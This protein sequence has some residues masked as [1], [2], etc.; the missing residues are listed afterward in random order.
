MRKLTVFFS[1]IFSLSLGFAHAEDNPMPLWYSVV[2][3]GLNP[4]FGFVPNADNLTAFPIV[5]VP[6][7]GSGAGMSGAFSAV[8]TDISFLDYNPAGSSRLEMSEFAFFYNSMINGANLLGTAFATRFGDM[9]FA[10]GAKWMYFPFSEFNIFGNRFYRSFYT[11]GLA[12]LNFSNNFLR[13]FNFSGI[14]IGA[15]LKG[16]VR[17]IPGLE[18]SQTVVTVMADV[19][20]LTQ[21]NF[22][23]FYQA[24]QRNA[25]AALVVRNIGPSARRDPLPTEIVAGLSYRPARMLLFAFDYTFPLNL[26]KPSNSEP[27]FWASGISIDVTSFLTLRGGVSGNPEI[28][29]FSVGSGFNLQKFMVELNYTQVFQPDNTSANWISLGVR[30]NLGDKG[31]KAAADA[32]LALYLQGIESYSKRDFAAAQNFWEQALALDPG[33]D[34]AR[35]GL[36]VIRRTFEVEDRV[37]ELQQFVF[38]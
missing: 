13:G 34:P 3:Q 14:S 20:A 27:S 2:S 21:F 38:E 32:V 30:F 17:I 11:E 29:R 23:K 5:R 9:G 10:A 35:E 4:I 25:A 26:D 37:L 33:F 8:A 12:T 7:G 24:R 36:E 19:G 18:K 22:L 16:A 15:N 1:I 6:M 31:R 28:T